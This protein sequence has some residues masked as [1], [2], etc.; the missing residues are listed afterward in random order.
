MLNFSE[1]VQWAFLALV[2]GGVY[3]LWQMKESIS[4]LNTKMEVLIVRQEKLDLGQDDHEKR[5]R[6][7]EQK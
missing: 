4:S 7:L 2:S 3:I 1:F 5:I 6:N